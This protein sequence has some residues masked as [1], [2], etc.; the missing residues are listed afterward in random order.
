[1]FTGL[2]T[3]SYQRKQRVA[4]CTIF[5]RQRSQ[6]RILAGSGSFDRPPICPGEGDGGQPPCCF[7]EHLSAC[8]FHRYYL[9]GCAGYHDNCTGNLHKALAVMNLAASETPSPLNLFQNSSIKTGGAL[10]I[11]PP[12]APPG[13]HVKLRT[14]M[15]IV[16]V[17]SACPQDMVPTNRADMTPKDAMLRVK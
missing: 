12:I 13:S 9:L 2:G 4:Y 10:V 3:R 7:P 6:I 15:E 5:R 17:F 1:M 8:D 11:E 16:M 14:G